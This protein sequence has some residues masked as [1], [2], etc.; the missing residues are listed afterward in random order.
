MS[1]LIPVQTA[2]VVLMSSGGDTQ[3]LSASGFVVAQRR[4]AVATKASGR[5]MELN[6]R[7]GSVVRRGELIAR[8]DASDAQ[9]VVAAA[10]AA[11]GKS[12]ADLAQAEAKA[13]QAQSELAYAAAQ[14]ERTEGLARQRFVSDQAVEDQRRRVSA[15]SADVMVAQAAVRQ[16]RAAVQQAEAQLALE[17]VNLGF[18]D[19]RAPFDGVILLKH[20]NVGDIITPFSSANG[21]QGAVV[22]MADMSSLE[23]EADIAEKNLPKVQVGQP[24]TILLDAIPGAR[25][26]GSVI[27][28]VPTVDRAKATVATTVAFDML[29]ARV[30]PGMSARLTYLQR[31]SAVAVP[32]RTLAAD[33]SAVVDRHGERVVLVVKREGSS[34]TIVE[35][36]VSSGRVIGNLVEV[37]GNLQPG[38]LLVKEPAAGL[39]AGAAVSVIAQ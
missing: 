26:T 5:L 32:T 29:D 20:A 4:T 30:L 8:L 24:V 23:V 16:G 7:A 36:P 14:T 9:A 2:P 35:V 15:A 1:R 25:F 19:I 34:A 18:T 33:P 11:V 31:Q 3:L 38:D 6:V 12:R 10:I 22:T 21:A 39:T 28:V 37:S 17:R 27:G 13:Q